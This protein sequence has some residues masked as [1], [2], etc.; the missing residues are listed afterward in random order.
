MFAGQ[1][2]SKARQLVARKQFLQAVR[3]FSD[4]SE[5]PAAYAH[6]VQLPMNQSYPLPT[7]LYSEAYALRQAK[8]N[9]LLFGALCFCMAVFSY[10]YLSGTFDYLAPP[11]REVNLQ[12]IKE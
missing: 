2:S 4:H 3:K 7:Q 10:C 9:K 6:R 5:V 12:L 11:P 8:N 1:L